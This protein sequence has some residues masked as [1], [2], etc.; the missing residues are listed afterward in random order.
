MF[1]GKAIMHSG[2]N[3]S[4]PG[5]Q[6]K[7]AVLVLVALAGAVLIGFLGVVMDLGH[8]FVTKTELQNAMDSCALAAARELKQDA[9]AI[10]RAVAAGVTAG[11]RNRIDFQADAAGV[12]AEDIWF[13]ARLS[14][15]STSFPFGYL[16]SGAADP[17]TARY[18]M[19]AR[20]TED[21]PTWFMQVLKGFLGMPPDASQV[22][23]L[24]TATMA[25]SQTTCAIPI[26]VCMQSN[27]EPYFGL[28][29]GKWY[30]GKFG[31]GTG[32]SLTGSYN[33]I[34]FPDESGANDIKTNLAGDGVCNLAEKGEKVGKQGQ[35]VGVSDAWNS[36][37]GVYKGGYDEASAP[38]DQTGFAY[39]ATTWPAGQDAYSHFL[40]QQAINAP[41]PADD[42]AGLGG[43]YKLPGK[44][45]KQ[46]RR[47]SI[48]PIVDCSLLENSN[49][50]KVPIAGYACILM[51][52]PIKGPI[53]VRL[54]YLGSPGEIDSPCFSAGLGGGTNGPLVPVLVH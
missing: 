26:G 49:P 10:Q 41:Y 48:A 25:P 31:T 23:A 3:G 11:N 20:T 9:Q 12:T 43:G 38:P 46:T 19:C 39:N 53:D 24:A 7:G 18:V 36:R 44:V 40:G 33:W 34:N 42:P 28:G 21:I 29:P 22:G 8:L 5:E 51:L 27:T 30:S 50:Q 1:I 13:S 4:S 15:N 52:S 6:Q 14:D 47:V 32:E 37:F 54:E 17:A 16:D 2:H 45:G 35:T